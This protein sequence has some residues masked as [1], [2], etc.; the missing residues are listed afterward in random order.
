VVTVF[1]IT[2]FVWM[3]EG[4]GGCGGK[5]SGSIKCWR[6]LREGR[7]S[8]EP[9]EIAFWKQIVVKWHFD[10]RYIPVISYLTQ[11][12]DEIMLKLVFQCSPGIANNLGFNFVF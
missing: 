4:E 2:A 5:I 6:K 11:S 1:A 12:W 3:E 10:R 7:E 8:V 9:P